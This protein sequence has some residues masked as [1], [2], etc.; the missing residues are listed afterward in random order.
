MWGCSTWRRLLRRTDCHQPRQNGFAVRNCYGIYIDAA[1][2]I[3]SNSHLA[4]PILAG[5]LCCRAMRILPPRRYDVS[6]TFLKAT[7]GPE[8]AV[9]QGDVIMLDVLMLALGVALFICFLGYTALCDA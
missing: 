7:R 1:Q 9:T 8:H 4:A 5:R 3:V 2:Q 6:G